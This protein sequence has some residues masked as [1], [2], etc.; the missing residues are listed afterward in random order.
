[1]SD[2]PATE[3]EGL[4]K[5]QHYHSLSPE[6]LRWRCDPATLPFKST[7]DVRPIDGVIGQDTAVEALRFGLEIYAPGQNVFVRGLTGTGRMTLVRRLLEEMQ[8]ACPRAKDCCYVH[9][10]AQPDRPRLIAL[11][12]G[13]APTFR[14]RVDELADFIRDE[15]ETA[16]SSEGLEARRAALE[17]EAQTQIETITTP[18]EKALREAGLALVSLQVGPVAQAA[19]FPLF[20]DKPVPPEEWEQLRSAGKVSEELD[21]QIREK[22]DAFE[23]QLQV[24]MQ[25]VSEIRRRLADS[26]KSLRSRAARSVL[27]AFAQ[28][29]R[30]EFPDPAVQVFLDEVINDVASEHARAPREDEDITRQYRVNLIL[31]HPGDKPCPIIMENS[32]TMS[33][34]LGTIDTRFDRDDPGRSDHLM[35]RA[36]S[37][38]RADGGY[39]IIEARDILREPGAW[40]VLVRTLRAGR[41]EI[42][43][44]ELE[45]PWRFPSLKPEPIDVNVKVILLGDS[46][47]FYLLDEYDPDFPHLFKVLADF[48][49]EIER[50]DETIA[51]YGGVIARIVTDENLPHFANTGVAELVEHGARIASRSDRLTTRFG[52]LADI[53]REAAFLARKSAHK[54]VTGED[55]RRAIRR[56]KQRANLPSKRF[57]ELLADGTIR[58]ATT[59]SAVGQ[60]NGLAVIHA[61][62]LTYGFPSR[63]TA[64]IGP[65]SAGV[66]NIEREADLSGAI[67]T[68]GFYI[69][70]GLLRYLLRTE[71]PLAFH[72]SVAFEQSYGGIDGDSASTAEICCLISALTDIPLRQGL[73]ITGAID[74]VGNVLAVGAVNEKTEGFFDTCRA[75]GLTG[76]QGVIIPKA[77]ARDLMLR[78]D[79]VDACRA[80]QFHVYAVDRVHEALELLTGVQAGEH[81]ADGSYPMNSILGVAVTRAFEYWMKAIP[82]VEPVEAPSPPAEGPSQADGE[83]PPSDEAPPPAE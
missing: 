73:A 61:G 60:V 57:L 17:Q 3:Q 21:A 8:P 36:G 77:N 68:K 47:T 46:E 48:D 35:I 53:A 33:N 22:H 44:P 18:F 1:M 34:L 83:Y 14:R 64:T 56:S 41:L 42:T 32:P 81:D 76:R 70:G 27:T 79:V 15:L 52:R 31:A 10:F 71:H 72:A 11:P 75:I 43:P 25:K 58:V 26:V 6:A 51:Q 13:R 69:L 50:N 16:L 74:Q 20:E 54:L 30:T 39:L 7:K 67:H 82:N 2:H 23:Q 59:G 40:K 24:V 9:N 66:I 65:G 49:S 5:A 12:R 38:L 63:I 80:H 62:P 19:L 28:K 78:D 29:L 45:F 37:L 55:V 4:A